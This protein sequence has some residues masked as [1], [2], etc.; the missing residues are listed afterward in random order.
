LSQQQWATAHGQPQWPSSASVP[1]RE[2]KQKG[3]AHLQYCST[4]PLRLSLK[5]RSVLRCNFR[6]ANSSTSHPCESRKSSQSQDSRTFSKR[7]WSGVESGSHLKGWDLS[8]SP[9]S[10]G[11]KFLVRDAWG[12]WMC[13]SPVGT[14]KRGGL[15]APLVA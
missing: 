13:G 8:R 11:S 12:G 7:M 14:R 3:N 1:C 4:T 15:A 5:L 2:T 10:V 6:A 9:D